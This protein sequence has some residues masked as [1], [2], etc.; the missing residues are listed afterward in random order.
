MDHLLQTLLNLPDIRVLGSDYTAQGAL[1]I[2][3]ESTVDSAR[4]RRCGRQISHF[5]GHDQPVRLRHLPIFERQVYLE[6]RPRRYRCPHCQGHP[7]T[8]QRCTWYEP[9]SPHTQ[10]FEHDMLRALINST[11]VDVSRKQALTPAA[12][13]GIVERHLAHEVDWSRLTA[14]GVI[15]IDEIALRKGHRDFITIVTSRHAAGSLTLLA[16]LPDRNKETVAAFLTAIPERLKATITQV[17][18][19]MYSGFVNAAHEELPEAVVVV[20][21][22]HVA[23]AYRD[24]AD[25]VRKKEVKRLKQT[26]SPA[27]YDAQVKGTLWLFRKPWTALTAA[28]RQRLEPLFERAPNLR[29]VHQMREVLT[30]IFEQAQ[31]KAQ[32][33]EWIQ[34]WR[35]FVIMQAIPGFEKFFTTLDNH[36]DE[37]TNYF[38]DR[39]TSGFV[40]GFNNKIKVLKRRC[41][42]L[43]NLTHLFQRLQLDL[44]GYQLFGHP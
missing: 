19:D 3:V 21:R 17:C 10:A 32:A 34:A 15:G 22:F 8:T 6:I 23:K 24:C 40:E 2:R 20:D 37:I 18:T 43:F 33:T 14:L 29:T 16:V 36:L 41:Y 30:A 5:H 42:G 28:E 26:L 38:L 9:N 4:C 12:V 7:T 39:Q 1:I 11:V 44:N 27:D 25:A 35:A 31:S 13:E